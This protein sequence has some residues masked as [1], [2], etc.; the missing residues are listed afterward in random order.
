MICLKDQGAS[1]LAPVPSRN[2]SESHLP[3]RHSP[4][5]ASTAARRWMRSRVPMPMLY[6]SNMTGRTDV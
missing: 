4:I 5:V 1:T 2:Q 3:H 6:G